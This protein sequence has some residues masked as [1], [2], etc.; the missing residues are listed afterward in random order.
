MRGGGYEGE[1]TSDDGSDFRTS[2]AD[3]ATANAWCVALWRR[4]AVFFL[5]QLCISASHKINPFSFLRR[6]R[7]QSASHLRRRIS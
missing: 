2:R 1:Q 5:G 3:V 7:S 4:V 6:G